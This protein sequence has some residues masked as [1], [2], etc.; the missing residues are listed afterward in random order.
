[1]EKIIDKRFTGERAEFQSHDKEYERCTF[2]DGESPLKEGK[3]LIVKNS[4]FGWKYPLWYT[5]NVSVEKTVWLET[6]R[7]GVW[8][9]ENL[10]ASDCRIIAP[11]NFRRCRGVSLRN[12][13]FE[14]ALET[15]WACRDVELGSVYVKGDY[16]GM[17]CE[18]V[19]ADGLTVDGNYCFDGGKNIRIE[20]SVLNSKDSFWNVKNA[21]VKN[22]TIKGE[23]IGW[24]SEN[25]T[26]I[27]C[28]IESHQGFCYINGLK[29]I[30]CSLENTDLAFEYCENVDADVTG[31]IVSVKNPFSGRIIA[32]DFGEIIHEKDKVDVTKT[33]IEKRRSVEV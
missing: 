6:A 12:V 17:N 22:S 19:H 25:L 4:F 28:K 7:S 30:N 20:N 10:Q 24:N 5:E 26:F 9:A 13:R 1:M 16:F 23:Y 2:D 11:K 14:N 8:Y 27:D 3:N 15:L 18:N 31:R 29:L 21:I 33:I 32:D